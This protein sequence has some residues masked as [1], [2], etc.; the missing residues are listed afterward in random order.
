MYIVCI[1][2][3][4]IHLSLRTLLM[5]AAFFFQGR[6]VSSSTNSASSAATGKCP[7]CVGFI[8]RAKTRIDWWLDWRFDRTFKHE[9]M[10][11]CM[12]NSI[13][14]RFQRVLL[15]LKPLDP[16]ILR[17]IVVLVVKLQIQGSKSQ[18][19]IHIQ[20]IYIYRMVHIYLIVTSSF[21]LGKSS[22][23]SLIPWNVSLGVPICYKPRKSKF[24]W[25][26]NPFDT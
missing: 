18:W 2:S 25:T 21:S 8:W 22:Y 26:P 24:L 23:S 6:C 7:S 20:Y 16:F 13:D 1:S 5:L 10:G 19:C 17:H 14:W 11:V 4:E 15:M 9:Q 3:L 12:D